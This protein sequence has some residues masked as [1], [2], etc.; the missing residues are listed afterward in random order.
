[1]NE[2]D[3]FAPP[4]RTVHRGRNLAVSAGL[5]GVAAAAGSLASE[6]DSPWYRKLDKPSWQPPSTA[7]PVVWSTLYSLIAATSVAVLNELD[8]RGDVHGAG[9]YR[10]ALARNLVLN[11]AWSWL[12]FRAHN[13]PAATAGAAALAANSIRLTGRA[14]RV[15]GRF[16]WALAPYALWTSFATVLAGTLWALNR[17]RAD[18]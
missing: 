2:P 6:P 10:R 12:F 8:R 16:G 13:L 18:S 3:P 17:G 1:M 4:R 11:G 7:F 15:G 5:V 9:E 14:G